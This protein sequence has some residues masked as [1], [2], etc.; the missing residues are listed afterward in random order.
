MYTPTFTFKAL[1]LTNIRT[2]KR[3]AAP[4]AMEASIPL[5]QL[6]RA[7]TVAP[8]ACQTALLPQM[9][10]TLQLLPKLCPASSEAAA[11]VA[12]VAAAAALP[13]LVTHQPVTQ[14]AAM[15]LSAVAAIQAVAAADWATRHKRPSSPAQ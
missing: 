8:A 7:P 10:T 2:L 1:P 13:A 6:P 11:Q 15:T 14:A 9:Q 12:T 3:L 5:P 4:A